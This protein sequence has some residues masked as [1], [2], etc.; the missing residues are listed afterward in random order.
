MKNTFLINHSMEVEKMTERHRADIRRIQAELEVHHQETVM[1]LK[2][3]HE[4]VRKVPK[5]LM[6]I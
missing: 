3:I 4:Q 1:K 5:S 2:H 6:M